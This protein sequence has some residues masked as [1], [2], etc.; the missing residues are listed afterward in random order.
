MTMQRRPS[1]TYTAL[2]WTRMGRRDTLGVGKGLREG[3][4]G[5]E[6]SGIDAF[7]ESPEA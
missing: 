7:N 5:E 1:V 2:S 6:E 3:R 4:N